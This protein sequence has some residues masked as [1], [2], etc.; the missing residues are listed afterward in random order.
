MKKLILLFS[1]VTTVVFAQLP[2]GIDVKNLTKDDLKAYGISD[3]E[4]KKLH[5]QYTA[6]DGTGSVTAKVVENK[7]ISKDE[8]LKEDVVEAK[9]T[10]I[11]VKKETVFGKSLFS[12]NKLEVYK[13]AS[14]IKAPQNYVLGTGDEISVSIWGYSE[15]SGVYTVANDG[16]IMPKLVGKMYLKGQT[17]ANA[18]KIIKSKFGKVFDLR[19]SQISIELNYSKV[20]RVNIVGEVLNPG[21]YTVP[22]INTL[23]NL[24]SITGGIGPN[25]SVR[26]ISVRR[27][28]QEVY[29][30]DVYKFIKNPE[31]K[32]DFY[33][34]DNDYVI[35]E[36]AKNIV[37]IEGGVLR[38]TSYELKEGEGLAH[39][40]DLAGGFKA[41]AY[42]KLINIHRYQNDRD[43]IIEVNY[44]SLQ[45]SKNKFV[46][47]NGDRVKI[48]FIPTEL[49][50]R[51]L[52]DGAV[53]IPGGYVLKKE[54]TVKDLV[55]LAQG[56]RVDAYLNKAYLTR[57]NADY[58]YTK[59]AINLQDELSGKAKTK[60]KE[61]D[62]LMTYSKK[63]FLTNYMVEIKG[64]VKKPKAY[65]YTD[66]LTLDDVIFMSGGLTRTAALKRIEISRIV[67]FDNASGEPAKVNVF[68]VEIEGDLLS[69]ANKNIK[70][71]ASDLIFVRE[72]PN[73]LIQQKVELKGEVVYPGTYVVSHKDETV[74]EF[75]MRA[76]GVT[77]HAFLGGAYLKR[78]YG[79]Q[80]G[81]FIVMDLEKLLNKRG[82]EYDYVLQDGDQLVIPS[83]VNM[84][85]L[86]GAVDFPK[87]AEYGSISTPYDK[88][89]RAK[90]YVNKYGSGFADDAKRSKTYVV[91]KGGRVKRTRNYVLFKIYPRVDIGDHVYVVLKKAKKE[92]RV[93]GDPFDWNRAI[94]RTTVKL[95]GLATLYVILQSAFGQ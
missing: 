16:S 8:L 47:Q 91:T 3:Y 77:D 25:G 13:S 28:G 9:V 79:E 11:A 49:R 89:K 52:V 87:V 60:L 14:H 43:E 53:N 4:M 85:Q 62:F 44:D 41:S 2:G 46:L 45:T 31:K 65:D 54:M 48:P 67:D 33:L 64:A 84:V 7:T 66:G 72:V 76:G 75:I 23:F 10:S 51:V 73:F 5:D 92:K 78:K 58:T 59:I 36:T 20:I 32:N 80:S 6:S 74:S 94:E 34:L 95:T 82:D 30:M 38:P 50:N 21:T 56:P 71:K 70:L 22:A 35:V 27:E 88:G 24:I 17:F 40:I 93:K 86:S 12:D 61:F 90:H 18:R 37:K 39:L 81:D 15:H 69:E 1:L 42:S 26:N 83:M 19:N 63:H 29:V 57:Q 55:D 68:T